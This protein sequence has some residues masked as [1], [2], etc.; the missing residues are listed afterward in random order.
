MLKYLILIS[1]LFI[2]FSSAN[3][4]EIDNKTKSYDLLP[5]SK[6]YIDNTK[7]LDLQDIYKRDREFKHNNKKLLAYGYAPDFNVWVKFTLKNSTDKPLNKIIEYGNPL[8]T[9][10]EFFNLTDNYVEKEGL[11]QVKKNRKTINPVFKIKL[12]ANESK[13]R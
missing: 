1:Y 7:S 3:I 4:L 5:H 2:S 6:I 8:A 9:H 13:T 11:F 10:I 12:Q